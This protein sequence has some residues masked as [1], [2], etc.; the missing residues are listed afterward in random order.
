MEW[1]ER[2]NLSVNYIEE[3]LSSEISYESAAKIACCSSFH[4][5]RMFSYIAG[6]PLSEYI[7][8]RRM[9]AAAFD[10]QTT[11]EKIVDIA[12]KYGYD[13]PTAFNRAFHNL[14]GVAP[15]VARAEGISLK[16][17]PRISFTISIKGESEMNYKINQ[18]EAFRI[19]GVKEHM[20]VNLE[21]NFTKVP[22]FWQQTTESGM[23]PRICA[24]M[25]QPPFGVLGV[26]TCMNGKEMNYYIAAASDQPVPEEMCDYEIPAATWAIFECVG[27]LPHA[28]QEMQR[29]IISEWL[30]ASNYEYA[31][32]PDI[33]VYFD[34]DQQDPNYR[35][36]V[37]LPITKKNEL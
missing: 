37:W 18:K 29:R 10:L 17:Y 22:V 24:L 14:H 23:L 12:L 8:R 31:E 19:V 2:L 27:P 33:E 32:A 34:G 5:Q 16:A 7:R 20:N 3:N 15:S 21:E 28:M 35:S 13:S 1:I 30:P 9:T 36:E 4:Y 6:V 25:N 11:D 26:S